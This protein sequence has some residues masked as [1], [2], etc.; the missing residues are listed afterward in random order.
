MRILVVGAGAVGGYFGGCLLRAGRDVRFLV[1]TKRAEQLD[2]DG[3]RIVS[4][5]AI[6]PRA[7]AHV[8]RKR[9]R[10]SET[11]CSIPEPVLPPSESIRVN[12]HKLTAMIIRLI[13]EIGAVAPCCPNLR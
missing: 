13:R 8:V 10:P 2:R 5:M 4:P 6:S 1:R 3:L 11:L 12:R 7:T 9:G